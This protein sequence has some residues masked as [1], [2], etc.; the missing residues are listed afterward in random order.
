MTIYVQYDPASADANQRVSFSTV[1][2]PG[3]DKSPPVINPPMVQIAYPDGTDVIAKML[4]L[5]QN[6]P[7]LIPTPVAPPMTVVVTSTSSPAINGTYTVDPQSCA[8]L[9]GVATRVLL[10]SSFPGGVSTYP[11][12]DSSGNPHNF[13]STATFN[14][15][16]TA[17]CDYISA[18]TLYQLSNGQSGSLPSNQLTIP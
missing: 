8:N 1:V 12:Y 16:A 4:D 13:T 9:N 11:W 10:N 6:P 3:N 5:S 17:I 7:A 2:R 14:A 18:L 15:F